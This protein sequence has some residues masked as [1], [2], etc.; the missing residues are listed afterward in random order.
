MGV[1]MRA[2]IE[3]AGI[4]FKQVLRAIAVV[5]IPVE[6]ENLFLAMLFLQV[7]RGNCNVV[8]KTKPQGSI[9]LGM[10]TGWANECKAVIGVAPRDL[11]GQI[12]HR[13]CGQAGN[14][15]GL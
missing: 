4:V 9:M 15:E 6:D 12:Q 13:A 3:N 11:I 2:H 10:V 1:L 8:K 5:D 7:A 14:I